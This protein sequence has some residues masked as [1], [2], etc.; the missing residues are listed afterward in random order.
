MTEV[1][2]C[3]QCGHGHVQKYICERHNMLFMGD[4]NTVLGSKSDSHSSNSIVVGY[5]ALA[6]HDN[7]IVIGNNKESIEPN[8]ITIGNLII[9]EKAIKLTDQISI[10]KDVP[11]I[12]CNQNVGDRLCVGNNESTIVCF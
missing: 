12:M 7:S 5:N 2:S 1:L 8:S 11:C 3:R 10:V 6:N 4:Y 9:T